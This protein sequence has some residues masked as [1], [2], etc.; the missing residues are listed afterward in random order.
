MHTMKASKMALSY[1][2]LKTWT[3]PHTRQR[4]IEEQDVRVCQKLNRNVQPFH[5]APAQATLHCRPDLGLQHSAQP[6]ALHH[7]TH[8]LSSSGRANGARQPQGRSEGK[9]VLHRKSLV[10]NVALAMKWKQKRM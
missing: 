2:N 1:L 4:L 10:E 9:L 7:L 5:F 8:P 6:K 3:K